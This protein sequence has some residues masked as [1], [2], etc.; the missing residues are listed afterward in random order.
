MRTSIRSRLTALLACAVLTACGDTRSSVLPTTSAP[1]VIGATAPRPDLQTTASAAC[2]PV[3]AAQLVNLA[4]AAFGPGSPDVAS[5][6][7][8]IGQLE[9]AVLSGDA[10]MARQVAFNI[11]EFT[12]RKNAQRALGGTEAALKTFINAIACYAGLGFTIDDPDG[13]YVV[14]P[15]D[16]AQIIYSA[17]RLAGI[18]LAA[19]TIQEPTIFSILPIPFVPVEPGDGPLNTK[20][21][22]YR[23]FYDF[24]KL[25]VNNLPFL[26]NLVVGVCAP[27]TLSA[28][29]F[30]RLRLGHDASTGFRLEP[31]ANADFLNC[32]TAYTAAEPR[33]DFF[34]PGLL[35][36]VAALFTPR[37]AFASDATAFF[38]GG[39]GGLASE[40]SPFA[41]VD[42]TVSFA[43]GV[44]GL[45]SELRI[46]T[47]EPTATSCSG[48]EAP[49][50]NA[51]E[52]ACR[53]KVI[54]TTELGTPLSG[55]PVTFTATIGGGSVALQNANGSCG[56]FGS[57]VVANTLADGSV[58]VC[59][60]LG[61]NP[62]QNRLRAVGGIGGDVPPGV[63]YEDARFFTATGNP[64]TG[65]A[66]RAQPASGATVAAGANIPVQVALVDKN[67]VTVTSFTGSVTLALRRAGAAAAFAAGSQTSAT[68]V[69]GVASFSPVSITVA[70]TGY[71]L[72]ATSGSYLVD[73]NS[74]DVV[75]ASVSTL[76]KVAGDLQSALAGSALAIQPTVLVRDAFGNP[77]VGA[78]VGW[79]PGGS[80]AG[81]V[82]PAQSTTGADGRAS[83]TWTV[84]S[85]AN[86]LLATSGGSAV[87]FTATGTTASLAVL[88]QCLPTGGGDPFNDPSKPNAFFIPDPGN[89]KTI[90]E[91]TVFLSSAGQANDV[92]RH[93]IQ[94]LITRGTFN[95]ADASARTETATAFLRGSNS[96]TKAIT[97]TLSQPIV[98]ASGPNAKKVMLRLSEVGPN[99]GTVTLNFNTG[100]CPPNSTRCNVPNTCKV[101]EVSSPLP[102]PEGTFYRQS[103][104]IT[105]RG[106]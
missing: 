90:R 97:F 59:W 56:T 50:G 58:Q 32:A 14:T 93:E 37:V 47:I 64:P 30:A 60:T 75:A 17:D 95:P 104:G 38:A 42:A 49:A 55:A 22:Q 35:G 34:A 71:S 61:G 83:T 16:G 102:Y 46:L 10:A 7:G 33:T 84:G 12:L 8:K 41:P 5:V 19:N 45:A 69:N 65:L 79:Q 57:S 11:I 106:N 1:A 13:V 18:S 96:E 78:V 74:F 44:G 43:G 63:T 9:S 26:Q 86:E 3:T 52:A 15:S 87:L 91:I 2:T 103:V 94:L 76:T 28:D 62:G 99:A 81:S 6:V 4:V 54:L 105:V 36:R 98:G 39:V 29:I 92:T 73:G 24:Q 72:R 67:N 101:T 77:V 25:S 48:T 23:G 88:N 20:L 66:F 51:I 68:A 82:S 53:P 21:D 70:N 89:N 31:P 27:A 40:L 100:P 85:G 80:S